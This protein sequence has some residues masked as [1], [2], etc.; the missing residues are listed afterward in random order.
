MTKFRNYDLP[1]QLPVLS[2]NPIVMRCPGCELSKPD[3][4]GWMPCW[5]LRM[6]ERMR[7]NPTI[8]PIHRSIYAGAHP[9]RLHPKHA[10]APIGLRQPRVIAAQFMGDLGRATDELRQDVLRMMELSSWHTFLVL[11]KCPENITE[12]VP[13]NCYL[14]TTGTD[15]KTATERLQKL[16]KCKA[17]HLWF[18]A[19]PM[20]GQMYLGAFLP[21]L[22]F[23]ACG[24]ET[25][26]RHM[27]PFMGDWPEDIREQCKAAG[28]PFYDKRDPIHCG[29]LDFEP[30]RDWP[31]EWKK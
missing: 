24:P 21:R 26:G 12:N 25:G 27:R 18:S 11:T 31:E 5:H 30:V 19:E 8:H 9:M 16:V 10:D 28:V 3:V 4:K 23:V 2:W 20:F 22:S 6:C 7:H 1:G 14:G 17:K 13:D 29:L 15:Q